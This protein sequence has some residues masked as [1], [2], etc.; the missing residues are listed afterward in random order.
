MIKI[1]FQYRC[2]MIDDLYENILV[3]G[4]D[5][6]KIEYNKNKF[7]EFWEC[8]INQVDVPS[9]PRT[10]CIFKDTNN[11]DRF[12]LLDVP[13]PNFQFAS[14]AIQCA[15]EEN[16]YVKQTIDTYLTEVMEPYFTPNHNTNLPDVYGTSR[17]LYINVLKRLDLKTIG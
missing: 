5:I 6:L 17:D 15:F 2:E 7:W 13:P 11:P 14:F 12:V 4:C 8:L 1:A 9:D 3:K 16:E 10:V